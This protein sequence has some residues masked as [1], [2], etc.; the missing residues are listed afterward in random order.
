LFK[1]ENEDLSVADLAGP[2]GFLDS[3]DNLIQN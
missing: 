2:G 1:I 3:L